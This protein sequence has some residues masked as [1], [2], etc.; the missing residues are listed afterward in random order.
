MDHFC[1]DIRCKYLSYLLIYLTSTLPQGSIHSVP[2]FYSFPLSIDHYARQWL[3][4]LC[5]LSDDILMGVL[6]YAYIASADVLKMEID[7]RDI[8]YRAILLI[9]LIRRGIVSFK[10]IINGINT[11][12]KPAVPTSDF[13]VQFS[14]HLDYVRRPG[15]QLFLQT[16]N[17]LQS[18]PTLSLTRFLH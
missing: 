11:K 7:Q 10:A 6:S 13:V 1:Q 18:I 4:K 8:I 15:P 17:L 5:C 14:S 3:S 9:P 12:S 2:S 16:P